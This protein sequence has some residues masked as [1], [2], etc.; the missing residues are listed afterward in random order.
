[1]WQSPSSHVVSQQWNKTLHRKSIVSCI[2]CE[3]VPCSLSM[4]SLMIWR[5]LLSCCVVS[6]VLV[7]APC[8]QQVIDSSQEVWEVA[9]DELQWLISD[10]APCCQFMRCGHHEDSRRW[11]SV[12]NMAVTV[13]V[14]VRRSDTD[15]RQPAQWLSP[16]CQHK[17][18]FDQFYNNCHKNGMPYL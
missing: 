17:N 16:S 14:N 4:W 12:N 2:P 7:Q 10:Q 18:S 9:R 13:N 11:S 1:M 5:L 8:K 3:T 15:W 6:A